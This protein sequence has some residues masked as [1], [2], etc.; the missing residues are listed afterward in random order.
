MGVLAILA[1][2][3]ISDGTT[4]L[5]LLLLMVLAVILIVTGCII[6]LFTWRKR[7]K[8]QRA[9]TDSANWDNRT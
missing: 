6:A 1:L 8:I 3:A 5:V 9:Y 2:S 7:L 4:R